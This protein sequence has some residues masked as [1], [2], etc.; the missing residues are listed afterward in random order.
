MRIISDDYY[1]KFGLKDV[2]KIHGDDLNDITIA[3]SYDMQTIRLYKGIS[4]NS[5]ERLFF[6]DCLNTFV[7]SCQL[8][9]G[10]TPLRYSIYKLIAER[11]SVFLTPREISVLGGLLKGESLTGLSRTSGLSPKTISA[12][13]NSALKKL[14]VKNLQVLHKDISSFRELFYREQNKSWNDS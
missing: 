11:K 12:Q 6:G 7:L 3:T 13:K 9:N 14:E 5:N 2:L 10:L 1:F 8:R 4:I